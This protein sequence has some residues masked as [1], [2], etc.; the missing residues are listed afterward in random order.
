MIRINATIH[1]DLNGKNGLTIATGS[2]LEVKPHFQSTRNE[3]FTAVIHDIYFDV[4]IYKSLASYEAGEPAVVNSA[5]R[6]FNVGYVEKN[7][8]IQLITSPTALQEVLV[9]H[10]ENGDDTYSGIGVGNAE[11]IYPYS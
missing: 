7:Y 2:V 11:V 8:D 1:T 4:V 10:I 5:I 3:D 9:S 6:E